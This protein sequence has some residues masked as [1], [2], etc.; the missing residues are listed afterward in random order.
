MVL[1]LTGDMHDAL[2]LTR[3]Q[4]KAVSL[5]LIAADVSR[6]HRTRAITYFQD[7]VRNPLVSFPSICMK[8]DFVDLRDFVV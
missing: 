5:V 8:T 2:S 1:L 7:F 4:M 3:I 6:R